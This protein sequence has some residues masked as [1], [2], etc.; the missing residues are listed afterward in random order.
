M[1]EKGVKK[2]VHRVYE[3][4]KGRGKGERLNEIL[5]RGKREKRREKDVGRRFNDRAKW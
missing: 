4:G 3:L 2:E 5:G 1:V